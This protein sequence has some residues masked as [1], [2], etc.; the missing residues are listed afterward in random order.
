[1]PAKN[2]QPT[3]FRFSTFERLELRTMLNGQALAASFAQENRGGGSH[4]VGP[5]IAGANHQNAASQST[6]LDAQLGST[7]STATG[8]V[9]IATRTVRGVTQT[10]LTATVTGATANSSLTV[11]VGSTAVGTI[12]TDASGNRTLVLSSNPS[13]TEQILPSNFPTNITSGTAVSVDTLTGTLAAATNSGCKGSTATELATQLTDSS[14]TAVGTAT[15]STSTSHGTTK[16]ALA[17]SVLGA[18]ANSSLDVSVGGV[19]VG[20]IT[21]NASGNGSLVLSSNP[22]GSQ[23]ALPSNFPTSVA[24]GTSVGVDTLSGTLAAATSS[25]HGS[26]CAD[27]S[28]G[29]SSSSSLASLS[30]LRR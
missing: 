9:T 7:D 5:A 2:R 24:A 13:G 29:S 19:T 23:Q 8:M 16:T 15:F 1:M 12:T 18:T 17:V 22:K 14:G 3:Y 6:V 11:S 21:T 25:G 30:L 26:H 20:T 27:D 4:F 28:S 10:E